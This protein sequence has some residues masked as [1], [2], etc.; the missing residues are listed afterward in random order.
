MRIFFVGLISVFSLSALAEN[1]R[2]TSFRYLDDQQGT[3]RAKIAEL[4]GTVIAPTGQPALIKVLSDHLSKTPG[5]Y[6]V[7][8]GKDGKF[9]TVIATYTGRASAILE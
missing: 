2:I 8:S 4:C 3:V 5:S 7:W 1:V 9:C 6:Y